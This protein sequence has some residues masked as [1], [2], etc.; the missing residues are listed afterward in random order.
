M[1]SKHLQESSSECSL[2][3][4]CFESNDSSG[5]KTISDWK[6]KRGRESISIQIG[7]ILCIPSAGNPVTISPIRL[8]KDPQSFWSS[9]QALHPAT[10]SVTKQ[11]SLLCCRC[12]LRQLSHD[13]RL[14]R[15]NVGKC[16]TSAAYLLSLLASNP[17]SQLS[18]VIQHC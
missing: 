13:G 1:L 7:C 4:V 15:T 11:Q 6:R 9:K 18:V 17:W 16:F 12:S 14:C 8:G 5:R 10:A 2:P 3:N